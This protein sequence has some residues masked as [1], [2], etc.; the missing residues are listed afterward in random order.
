MV[1]PKEIIFFLV[2]DAFFFFSLPPEL[3]A[4]VWQAGCG[5]PFADG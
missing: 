2:F 4:P 1:S 3:L 5:T